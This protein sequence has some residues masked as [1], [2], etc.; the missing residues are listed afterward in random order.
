MEP[1]PDCLLFEMEEKKATHWRI[2]R[3][4]GRH[5]DGKWRG[6]RRR[7]RG[8][9][10]RDGEVLERAV[11]SNSSLVWR[12]LFPSL[13]LSLS[14]SHSTYICTSL[15]EG[16]TTPYILK[17]WSGPARCVGLQR[18]AGLQPFLLS[19]PSHS[20]LFQLLEELEGQRSRT[21]RR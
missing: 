20:R 11:V 7:R 14:L 18:S 2:L 9:L 15:A 4:P 17:R 21:R 3:V 13:N 6:G 12:S 1:D 8:E 16:I 19:I 10:R 5:G